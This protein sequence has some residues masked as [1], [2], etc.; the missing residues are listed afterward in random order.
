MTYWNQWIKADAADLRSWRGIDESDDT[1]AKDEEIDTIENKEQ[2]D[3]FTGSM[4]DFGLS[5]RD[6]L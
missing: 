5:W 1:T 6:F 3:P 4:F 2:E